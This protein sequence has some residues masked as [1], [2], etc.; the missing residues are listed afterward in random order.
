MRIVHQIGLEGEFILRNSK[1]DVVFP[2]DYGFSTDEFILLGE[3]RANPGQDRE[4]TVGNFMEKIAQVIYSARKQKL[5]ADFSGMAEIT[6]ELKA[7]AV[8]KMGA[9]SVP[10]CLNLY[11]TDILGF[12]DD[13]VEKGKLIASRISAGLHVHFSRG[14]KS[15]FVDKDGKTTDDWISILMDSQRNSIIRAFDKNVLPGYSLGVPLKYRQPGFYEMKKWGFEYRSL[16]MVWRFLEIN[17]IM[18]L[19]DYA[20]SQLEKLEK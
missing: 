12:S 3:F 10:S 1:G 6:P 18:E 4:E 5:M 11:K 15:R 17:G 2:G 13:I 9:K 14:A 8:K 19:V 16:P 7:E 20:Y